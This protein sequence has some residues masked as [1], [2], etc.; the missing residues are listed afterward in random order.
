MRASIAQGSAQQLAAAQEFLALQSS[1]ASNTKR[2]ERVMLVRP[3]PG[4]LAL[5][6]VLTTLAR[7]LVRTRTHPG[8]DKRAG[9]RR[10]LASCEQLNAAVPRSCVVSS[11]ITA[12][13]ASTLACQVWLRAPRTAPIDIETL[14]AV[15]N[16]A[17]CASQA[18]YNRALNC[19]PC[20]SAPGELR[21]RLLLCE[22]CTIVGNR[23]G[24]IVV[25]DSD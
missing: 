21:A 8:E 22:Q 19:F 14:V 16:F 18:H 9:L 3:C 6:L 11:W 7:T 10:T 15:T 23:Q 5:A 17:M 4:P 12:Y 1:E 24:A 20:P 2:A 25:D 13:A